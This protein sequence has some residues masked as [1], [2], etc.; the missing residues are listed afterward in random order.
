ME[1][2]LS[3]CVGCKLYTLITRKQAQYCTGGVCEVR[4]K[5]PIQ[6]FNLTQK[7]IAFSITIA[8]TSRFLYVYGKNRVQ[9][10]LWG[11]FARNGSD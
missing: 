4:T 2:A 5:E 9:N 7:I 10:V 1:S 8:L 3:I 11:V 6:T